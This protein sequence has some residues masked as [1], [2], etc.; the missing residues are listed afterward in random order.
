[1][2]SSPTPLPRGSIQCIPDVKVEFDLF[3]APDTKSSGE[4]CAYLPA[5]FATN[6]ELTDQLLFDGKTKHKM[7]KRFVYAIDAKIW[8]I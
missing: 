4:R 5:E 8:I 6:E 3:D 2:G 1:M 7:D